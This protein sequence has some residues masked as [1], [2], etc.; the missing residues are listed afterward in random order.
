MFG[1]KRDCHVISVICDVV[2]DE[3]ISEMAKALE[4]YG[5]QLPH[6]GKIGGIL[7]SEIAYDEAA[8]E[9]NMMS[10]DITGLFKHKEI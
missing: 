2:T 10:Y 6:F 1:H 5:I 4:K 3:E 8:S 7:A 9:C